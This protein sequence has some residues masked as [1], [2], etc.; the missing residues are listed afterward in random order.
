M[1]KCIA[2]LF[3]VTAKLLFAQGPDPVD[4]AFKRGKSLYE[5]SKPKDAI[6]SFQTALSGNPQHQDALYYLG[7][8]YRRTSQQQQ[9]TDA[10]KKLEAINPDYNSQFYFE[11]ACAYQELGQFNDAVTYYDSFLAKVPDDALH[12]AIIH[13]AKYRKDYSQKSPEVRASAQMMKDPIRLP[14]PINSKFDDYFPTLDPTGTKLYFTTVLPDGYES[15]A[16][17][18]DEDIYFIEKTGDVWSAPTKLPE[19]LNTKGNDGAA[20]FSADGQLMI[21]VGCQRADGVGDCDLYYAVN[22]DGKW[23]LPKNMG[24]IVNSKEWD[25]SPSLSYDGSK[26]F[27]SSERAGGYGKSD[28]YMVEKNIFGDWGTPINLGSIVNTP[29]DETYP[30]ISQDGKTLYFISNGHPGYGAGDIFKTVLENG[31]WSMPV[32]LGKPLN[33]PNDEQLFSIGGAGDTGYFASDQGNGTGLDIYQI[34]IP[35]NMRPQPTVIV[36][37]IVSDDKTQD[38]LN[39]YVMVED[40]NTGELIASTKSN[41]VS[42]KY[43][44]VLVA[45]KSYIVSANKDGYFFYSQKFDVP[46]SAKFAEIEQN[47]SM[48]PIEKGTK[49]VLNNIFFESGR[50]TLSPESGVELQKAFDLLSQNT[51]MQIEIGGH[52]DN[53]GN[54]ASNLQLSNDRAKAVSDYLVKKGISADRIQVKGYGDTRPVADNTTDEGRKTNRRIEFTTI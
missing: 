36:S 5:G 52:T 35:E 14:E 21:Y 11:T 54:P 33:T 29:F 24:N 25:S 17:G 42:G 53:V 10:F 28:I 43:L 49:I 2:L 31:K 7:L 4:V 34:E 48:K 3:V 44:A 1:K 39:A 37:G 45:G 51:S 20:S 40:I 41:S 22:E 26:L 6:V 8:C 27:F 30:F 38:P 32:N 18:S 9:A 19:P 16:A 50:A 13:E 46:L 12:T 23:S 15:Q 47:I